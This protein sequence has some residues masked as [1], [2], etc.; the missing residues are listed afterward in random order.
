MHVVWR[1]S[2]DQVPK[3]EERFRR[4]QQIQE[5]Q[6]DVLD[7]LRED[8][9]LLETWRDGQPVSIP[10]LG[11]FDLRGRGSPVAARLLERI[12]VQQGDG[13]V[14]RRRTEV[15]S[16]LALA[17]ATPPTAW[18]LQPVGG[19]YESPAFSKP[20]ARR[21]LEAAA[22]VA[23]LQVLTRGAPLNPEATF[24]PRAPVWKLSASERARLRRA[25]EQLGQQL[26]RLANS[27]RSDWGIAFLIE[28]A[29]L[30]ALEQSLARGSFVFLDDLPADAPVLAYRHLE[31]RLDIVAEMIQ[32]GY[33][34][35]R[36][37]RQTWALDSSTGERDWSRVEQAANRVHELES[38]VRERRGLRLSRGA[39]AP[40]RA[41][42]STRPLPTASPERLPVLLESVRERE[43][44]VRD[45]LDDLYAY[46][47]IERNCVSE[48]FRTIDDAFGN[49]P[50]ETV[51]ALGGHVDG[52]RGGNF[53]PFVSAWSVQREYR[54]ASQRRLPAYR[55]RRVA[56]MKRSENPLWVGLRESNT[57]TAESYRRGH[58]DSFFL[59]FSDG[60]RALRPL[61]G[62][63]NL[64]AGIGESLWG[65]VQLPADGGETLVSGLEGALV[66]LPELVFWNIRKGSNDWVPGTGMDEI[67][68]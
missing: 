62:A 55:E 47:L 11:L 24:A 4:R 21:Y 7:A 34:Q 37:A 28:L 30:E 15:E 52:H 18:R 25:R 41:A 61:F 2:E 63:L 57:L 14:F 42:A 8:R 48:L 32:V 22:G 46:Q 1:S 10:A 59:F 26:T 27:P 23:A 54:V 38:A 5:R 13:F 29:R 64:A 33:A 66:S 51:S 9:G 31:P 44:R 35:L 65:L 19:V 49:A 39:R 36:E 12:E 40:R 16:R 3:L 6:L 17:A 58:G 50:E 60:P 56:Q 20:F 67:D 68:R 53:I 43:A 45:A